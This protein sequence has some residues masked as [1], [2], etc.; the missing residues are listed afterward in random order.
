MEAFQP[1]PAEATRGSAPPPR[2]ACGT[3]RRRKRRPRT[4]PR[5]PPRYR[6]VCQ[7]GETSGGQ[8]K[9]HL[10]V[11]PAAKNRS[12]L[13]LVLKPQRAADGRRARGPQRGVQRVPAT[14]TQSYPRAINLTPT[15]QAGSTPTPTRLW[16]GTSPSDR[17]VRI[18][19]RI[20]HIGAT[21]SGAQMSNI[22]STLSGVSAPHVNIRAIR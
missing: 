21:L 12:S 15:P 13:V 16:A 7:T 2:W 22:L 18:C 10:F 4:A 6:G 5:T 14:R 11:C 1:I 17:R 8:E 9:G 19:T 20:Q 3:A